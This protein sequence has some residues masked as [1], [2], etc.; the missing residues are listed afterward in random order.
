MDTVRTITEN[1]VMSFMED[2]LMM[3]EEGEAEDAETA[4]NQ[5]SLSALSAAVSVINCFKES[6]SIDQRTCEAIGPEQINTLSSSRPYSELE[7][8]QLLIEGRLLLDRLGL[9][10]SEDPYRSAFSRQ[11]RRTTLKA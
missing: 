11:R 3:V 2:L 5:I 9:D 6:Q 1:I 7:L 4:Y 8:A 10:I